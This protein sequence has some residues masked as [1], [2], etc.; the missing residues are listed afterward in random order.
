M[1]PD[2]FGNLAAVPSNSKS[3]HLPRDARENAG[4]E[5]NYNAA[6]GGIRSDSVQK[7]PLLIGPGEM[8]DRMQQHHQ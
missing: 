3:E 5:Q 7:T 6:L 2:R 1:K 4:P 8:L